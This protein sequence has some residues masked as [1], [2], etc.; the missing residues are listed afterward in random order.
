MNS[1]IHISTG[2]PKFDELIH[3]LEKVRL[4]VVGGRSA[5]GKSAFVISIAKNVAVDQRI[6]IGFFSLELSAKHIT[7]RLACNIS[8]LDA[9][10]VEQESW[11]ENE[12]DVFHK[13]IE[14]LKA[15]PIY[16]D[17]TPGLSIIEFE[18][19][20]RQM[21]DEHNVKLFFVDYLQLMSGSG[22]IENRIREY[23]MIAKRLRELA[24]KLNIT[25]I[26]CSQLQD[27]KFKGWKKPC[28]VNLKA[29]GNIDKYADVVALI[30]RPEYY[31]IL[32]SETKKQNKDGIA[33]FLVKKNTIGP[34]GRFLLRFDVGASR[35]YSPFPH[36]K[37]TRLHSFSMK[38]WPKDMGETHGVEHWDRV[39]RFGR[40]LHQEG[41]DM[42]VVL[43][44]AY[45]HDSERKDNAEDI[46][47]GKRASL[48]IDRIRETELRA[49]ND[50]QIA[51][52]KR[53]CEFHTIEHRTDDLTIDTCFDAD[54]MDLLRVGIMP[55][56]KRMATKRGADLVADPYYENYYKEIFI[57]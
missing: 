17:D 34:I 29:Y 19:K 23:S 2:F 32:S 14:K 16:I 47:H 53:A 39:A 12:R 13:G 26:V 10:K 6:P 43:A 54:R 7:N 25:I 28:L 24:D 37:L 49:L 1:L 8:E 5:M 36:F 46:E 52:L 22:E 20:A 35:F 31:C 48:L 33:E 50:E 15:C 45:L 41:V 38:R 30:H 9:K 44:F 4:I 21:I 56:P 57:L 27:R 40:M 55:D 11:D 18:S 42:D 51:K 3:G